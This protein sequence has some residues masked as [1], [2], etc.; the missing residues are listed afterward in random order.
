MLY[1]GSGIF[2]AARANG[3]T[4]LKVLNDGSQ[5]VEVVSLHLAI[6]QSFGKC[7]KLP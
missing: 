2:T 5:Y 6:H 4:F 3:G 1:S 7:T